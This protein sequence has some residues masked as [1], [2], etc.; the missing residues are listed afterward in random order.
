M[1]EE[2]LEED[3]EELLLKELLEDDGGLLEELLEYVDEEILEDDN[4]LP[5]MQ[6]NDE[7][8]VVL[9]EL[10]DGELL[11]LF[12]NDV[13]LLVLLRDDLLTV[14]L[15]EEKDEGVMLDDF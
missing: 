11:Q 2:L 8:W 7:L 1:L 10:T 4:E 15:I 5:Q 13:L 9:W 6:S 12:A 3:A 14:E